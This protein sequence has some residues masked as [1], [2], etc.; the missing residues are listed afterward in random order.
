MPVW[1]WTKELGFLTSWFRFARRWFPLPCSS[2]SLS[3]RSRGVRQWD[4]CLLKL[5][6]RVGE[7]PHQLKGLFKTQPVGGLHCDLSPRSKGTG[8]MQCN[9]PKV[10]RRREPAEEQ[11]DTSLSFYEKR[12]QMGVAAGHRRYGKQVGTGLEDK[13]LD[14]LFSFLFFGTGVDATVCG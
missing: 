13:L 3:V 7:E 5:S 6:L 9:L 8:V 14:H 4:L 11:S 10:V 1:V 2:E 12:K